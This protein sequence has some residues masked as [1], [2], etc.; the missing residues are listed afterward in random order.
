MLGQL[1]SSFGARLFLAAWTTTDLRG[2]QWWSGLAPWSGLSTIAT[3]RGLKWMESSHSFV[4][5]V[6]ENM[7]CG[8]LCLMEIAL[9]F[10]L[11]F[12]AGVVWIAT[13][14]KRGDDS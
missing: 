13:R 14:R 1:Q 7:R 2:Y 11:G 10:S 5:W 6:A 4:R 9:I 12:L 3:G 8:L